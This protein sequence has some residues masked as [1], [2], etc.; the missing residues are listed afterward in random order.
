MRNSPLTLSCYSCARGITALIMLVGFLVSCQSPSQT[1]MPTL[2][3]SQMDRSFLTDK[4]C[5]APCW[6]GLELRK[7]TKADVLTTLRTLS[8]VNPDT[9]QENAIG[10]WDRSSRKNLSATVI[11]VDYRASNQ[12]SAGLIVANNTL[13]SIGISPNY[14]LSFGQVVDHLGPPDYV[15]AITEP[16]RTICHLELIW[17]NRQI[18]VGRRELNGQQLCEAMRTGKSLDPNLIVE[19]IHYELPQWFTEIPAPGRDH[20]WPGFAKP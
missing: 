5:P 2:D 4:P 3:A 10:Y 6:Y 14:P 19:E 12:Q 1:P 7:S 18:V 16:D 9:I 20:P 13:L 15:S 8:F 11:G 17:P